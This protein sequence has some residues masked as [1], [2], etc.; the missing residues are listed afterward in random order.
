M[1]PVCTP[2]LWLLECESFL[3]S[4]VVERTHGC[5][6]IRPVEHHAANDLDAR[7]QCD[8]IGRKPPRCM[9]GV[10]YILL[11]ADKSD[12]ERIARYAARR[13][14]H[15]WQGSQTR[16]AFVMAPQGWQNGIGEQEIG[17]KH[18]DEDKCPSWSIGNLLHRN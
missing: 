9:H 13:P 2:A 5:I 15:H 4:L 6:M 18:T 16:L 7:A 14:G 17:D 1:A 10:K 3:F 12:V 11:A 8:R